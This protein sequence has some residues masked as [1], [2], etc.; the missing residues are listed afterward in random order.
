MNTSL[1]EVQEPCI[2]K[3]DDPTKRPSYIFS[4]NPN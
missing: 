1:K 2:Q 3:K 4:N